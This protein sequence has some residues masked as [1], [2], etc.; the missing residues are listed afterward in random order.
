MWSRPL[1]G[2]LFSVFLNIFLGNG[3]GVIMEEYHAVTVL[4]FFGTERN[5][6]PLVSINKPPPPQY[7]VVRNIS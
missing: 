2:E 7:N 6:A 3:V 1:S 4:F 5:T